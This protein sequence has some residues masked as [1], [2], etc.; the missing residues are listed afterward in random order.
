MSQ[1]NINNHIQNLQRQITNIAGRLKN[2]HISDNKQDFNV[3]EEYFADKFSK[4]ENQAYKLMSAEA[5]Y[6]L[7]KEET[8]TDSSYAAETYD[9]VNKA[10][11]KTT[12]VEGLYFE[13]NREFDF[14]V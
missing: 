11:K 10:D 4:V 9:F 7:L 12:V 5:S 6:N 13:N 14:K 3:L 2:K 8:S 1:N